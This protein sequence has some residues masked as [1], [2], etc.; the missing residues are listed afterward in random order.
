MQSDYTSDADCELRGPPQK[1]FDSAKETRLI[2]IEC[3]WKSVLKFTEA[4]TWI[5]SDGGFKFQSSVCDNRC[6]LSQVIDVKMN[7]TRWRRMRVIYG[8][9]ALD[10]SIFSNHISQI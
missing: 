5:A 8:K 3:A 9:Q 7:K 6:S 2:R 1:A 4:F 10:I